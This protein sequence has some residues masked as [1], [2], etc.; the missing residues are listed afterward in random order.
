MA[1]YCNFGGAFVGAPGSSWKTQF[2]DHVV[3]ACCS[4]GPSVQCMCCCFVTIGDCFRQGLFVHEKTNLIRF[5]SAG[6]MK[7]IASLGFEPTP[8]QSEST[9]RTTGVMTTSDIYVLKGHIQFER[10]NFFSKI[11]RH[12]ARHML[13]WG[14]GDFKGGEIFPWRNYPLRNCPRAKSPPPPCKLSK[15]H[16]PYNESPP[17]PPQDLWLEKK[18]KNSKKNP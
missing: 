13:A 18:S 6:H 3:P 4:F 12:F 5:T 8:V 10:Q 14:F 1:T 11:E 15:N 9:A 17:P 16:R 2:W 7:N